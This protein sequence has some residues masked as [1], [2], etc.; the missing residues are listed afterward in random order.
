MR[1]TISNK[2]ANLFTAENLRA[3]TRSFS[4]TTELEVFKEILQDYVKRGI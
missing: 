4:I 1:Y 2:Q 3:I